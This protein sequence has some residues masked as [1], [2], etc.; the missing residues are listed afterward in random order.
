MITTTMSLFMT[1]FI[2]SIFHQS[3]EKEVPR[4]L[5]NFVLVFLAKITCFYSKKPRKEHFSRRN[6]IQER[7]FRG[8]CKNFYCYAQYRA[9]PSMAGTASLVQ[10]CRSTHCTF[11]T[12][13]KPERCKSGSESGTLRPMW[14]PSL[15]F[16][17]ECDDVEKRRRLEGTVW[18]AG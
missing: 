13:E 11:W 1:V 10:R 15:W 17:Q 6:E 5:K 7:K 4:W 3:P 18:R 2:V 8:T 14:L 9:E 12:W 16:Q